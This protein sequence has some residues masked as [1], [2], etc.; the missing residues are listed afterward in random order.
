VVPA[1]KIHNSQIQG[2]SGFE[3][4]IRTLY[5]V[6]S[7]CLR[8]LACEPA[9]DTARRRC[10]NAGGRRLMM[11]ARP[12]KCCCQGATYVPWTMLTLMC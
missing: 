10:C 11:Q 6:D 7:T 8:M 1:N 4:A 3:G 9:T 2:V 12:P 5:S